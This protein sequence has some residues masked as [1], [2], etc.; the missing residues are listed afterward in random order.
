MFNTLHLMFETQ[1]TELATGGGPRS[2]SGS[3]RSGYPA[4]GSYAEFAQLSSI[5]EAEGVPVGRSR[6]SRELVRGQEAVV[7]TARAVFPAAER[8]TTS[9]PRTC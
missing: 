2:P 1:Y 4:P 8:R 3:A 7:Q 5:K 9:R 6:W